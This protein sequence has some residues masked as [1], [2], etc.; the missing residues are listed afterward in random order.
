MNDGVYENEFKFDASSK[1]IS[2]SSI[3]AKFFI[4]KDASIIYICECKL[5]LNRLIYLQSHP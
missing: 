3:M 4:Y 2:S 1:E 5:R